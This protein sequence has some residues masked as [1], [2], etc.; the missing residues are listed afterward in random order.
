MR[1]VQHLAPDFD[2]LRTRHG[3]AALDYEKGNAADAE[4]A[5]LPLINGG[6]FVQGCVAERGPDLSLIEPGP[7]PGAESRLV[8]DIDRLLEIGREQ[9]LDSGA[10]APAPGRVGDQAMRC[11]RVRRPPHAVEGEADALSLPQRGHVS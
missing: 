5:G 9:G 3:P 2:G 1:L 4:P 6:G 10:G 11:A 7:G 8:A